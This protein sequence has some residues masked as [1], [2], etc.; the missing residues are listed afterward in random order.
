MPKRTKSRKNFKKAIDTRESVIYNQGVLTENRDTSRPK[1]IA[2]HSERQPFR[3]TS[4]RA[5]TLD[6]PY[7]ITTGQLFQACMLYA[8]Q[9]VTFGVVRPA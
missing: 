1:K 4:E 3:L 9:L 5:K 2:N 8:L 7:L 6:N